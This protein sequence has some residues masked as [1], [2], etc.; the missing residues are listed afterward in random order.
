M[1]MGALTGLLLLAGACLVL[2][3]INPQLVNLNLPTLNAVPAEQ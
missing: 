3:T 1:D 2:H